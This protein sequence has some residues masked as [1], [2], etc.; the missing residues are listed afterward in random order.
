M[1]YLFIDTETTVLPKDDKLSPMIVDNW[2]RL[3]SLAYILC[4]DREIM[5]GIV[6]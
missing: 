2:P 5:V 6:L 3:V 4:D 1:K